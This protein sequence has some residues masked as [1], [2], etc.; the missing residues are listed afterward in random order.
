MKWMLVERKPGVIYSGGKDVYL[1]AGDSKVSDLD[2]AVTF[3][4]RQQAEEH[5]RTLKQR[6]DWVAVVVPN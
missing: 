5:R 6:Y 1:G 4:T 2:A 3:V